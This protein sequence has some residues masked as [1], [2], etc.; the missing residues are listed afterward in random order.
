MSDAWTERTRV[1]E[2]SPAPPMEQCDLVLVRSQESVLVALVLDGALGRST[3]RP[4]CPRE[5]LFEAVYGPFLEQDEPGELLHAI[6]ARMR[7]MRRG[8]AWRMYAAAAALRW[9]TAGGLDV[10]EIGDTKAWLIDGGYAKALTESGIPRAGVTPHPMLGMDDSE[11]QLRRFSRHAAATTQNWTVAL[12]TDGA[13]ALLA[14]PT[15]DLPGDSSMWS[16]DE[17]GQDDATL[18]VVSRAP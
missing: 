14:S 11:A 4:P 2:T 5:K 3:A 15:G 1:W 9:D 13:Y 7:D 6:G 16:L 12:M 17:V 8:Q 10:A 18:L